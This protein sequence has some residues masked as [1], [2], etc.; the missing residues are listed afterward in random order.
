M[1]WHPL[2]ALLLRPLLQDYYDVQTDLPVGDKPRQADMVLVRRTAQAPFVGIWRNLTTWNALEFKGPTDDPALRDLD[3]LF[4]VGLGIDRRLNEERRRQGQDEFT[5]AEVS[6]WYL[7]NHVGHRFRAEAERLLGSLEDLDAGLWR[8]WAFGHP[9]LIVSRDTIVVDRESVPLH[10]V[11]QES[12]ERSR[13]LAAEVVREPGFWHTYGAYL[14]E[15][16]LEALKEVLRMNPL[17]EKEPFSDLRPLIEVLGVQRVI[18]QIGLQ[19]VID[20]VGLQRLIDQVGL[21]RLIDQ[22]GLQRLIDQ[23]GLQ[24]VIDQA[25]SQ[26]TPD[27]LRELKKRLP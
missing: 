1:Q 27:Q 20:Q 21:Q 7:A 13:A 10:L 8:G 24:H 16:H 15:L 26:M 25:L 22:V 17:L 18:D 9:F 4:E 23:V 5:R 14:G 19:R 6:W 11:T 3:L 2:F 12:A